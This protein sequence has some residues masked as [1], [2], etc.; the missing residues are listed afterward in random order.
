[1]GACCNPQSRPDPPVE[2]SATQPETNVETPNSPQATSTVKVDTNALESNRKIVKALYTYDTRTDGDLSFRKNERLEILNDDDSDWWHARN[3][4]DGREGYIPS[5]YVALVQT[6][7]AEDW[8]LGKIGRKEAENQLRAPGNIVGTFLIRESETSPGMFSLS[9]LDHDAQRGL[10]VK[11]YKIKNLDGNR[12]YFITTRK[13][14]TSLNALVAYYQEHADGL[15]HR[16]TQSCP[17]PKPVMWD[18]SRETRDHWEIE[19]DSLQ[20]EK[21]I[22]NG[23]FG[24]VWYGTWKRYTEVA[25]KTLKPGTMSPSA[26]LEEAKIMKKCRHD[27]LVQLYAVCTDREPIYIVTEFMVNGSLLDY[28]RQGKGKDCDNVTLIDIAAQI[29]SGMA[30][31]EMEKLIHRDLAAR[32]ILVGENNIAKVADFGLA[33]IIEDDEY[34]ARQG[35]K[36]PI[37]WTAPEAALLGKFTTKSDVWSYGVLLYEVFTKGHV[38]YPGMTNR[39]VLEALERGYRM[40]KS[41][42]TPQQAYDVQLKCWDQETHNRPTFEFLFSFFDDFNVASSHN[43]EDQ[44]YVR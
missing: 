34:S 43:Y 19:R 1:M 38:P 7:D 16:L 10:V 12:G 20:F 41:R 39:E 27:R 15:C 30:Y 40:P 29:A 42:Q 11:H 36:F 37:K 44:S 24:E 33:R 28:L 21:K 14:F 22:G 31:L 26:F 3:L 6:V 9:I 25:I 8:Y 5:N 23:N 18:M 35:A 13:T 32:N 2:L 17:K 4:A